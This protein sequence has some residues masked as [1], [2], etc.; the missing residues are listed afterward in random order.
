MSERHPDRTV[1]IGGLAVY[2]AFVAGVIA[3]INID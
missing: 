1:T 3:L 2:V